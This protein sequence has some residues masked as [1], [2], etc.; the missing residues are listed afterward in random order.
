MIGNSGLIWSGLIRIFDMIK[1][2]FNYASILIIFLF[3]GCAVFQ[4]APEKAEISL[5]EKYKTKAMELE[6]KD[7]F[8][9]ALYYWK[10]ADILAVDD[11]KTNFYISN[12]KERYVNIF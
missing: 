2:L 8:R 3:Y 1:F 9:I 7:E 11:G 10:I 5:Y 4:K 6:E 12:L